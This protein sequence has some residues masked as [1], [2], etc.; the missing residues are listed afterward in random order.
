[1]LHLL[2]RLVVYFCREDDVLPGHV[3][4][5]VRVQVHRQRPGLAAEATKVLM[6]ACMLRLFTA[7][8]EIEV[9][10]AVHCYMLL[11]SMVP[12]PVPKKRNT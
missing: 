7:V 5:S 1:M 9:Q 10:D 11:G 12:K 6:V 3:A 2:V 8:E 4:G